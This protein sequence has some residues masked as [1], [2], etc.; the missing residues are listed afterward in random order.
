MGPQA[1]LDNGAAGHMTTVWTP[2]GKRGGSPYR[3]VWRPNLR[4]SRCP[5]T[6]GTPG[7][8]H[9]PVIGLVM[10]A[11]KPRLGDSP[12]LPPWLFHPELRPESRLQHHK[13]L[14]GFWLRSLAWPRD[15]QALGHRRVPACCLLGTRPHSRKWAVGEWERLH[16]YLQP[17]P[18][19]INTTWASNDSALW[20]VLELFHYIP[21]V[22]I[23]EIKYTIHVICLN[24]LE[25][26]PPPQSVENVPS[27]K[28]VPD[29][30]KGWEP[31]PWPKE[32]VKLTAGVLIPN[33]MFLS[34]LPTSLLPETGPVPRDPSQGWHNLLW[35]NRRTNRGS[36]GQGGRCHSRRHVHDKLGPEHTAE[37]H[38]G[39]GPSGMQGCT[40]ESAGGRTHA[41]KWQPPWGH[42]HKSSKRRKAARKKRG[43]GSWPREE[44]VQRQ[45]A[46]RVLG[47]ECRSV[48]PGRGLERGSEVETRDSEGLGVSW[49]RRK[50]WRTLSSSMMERYADI[51]DSSCGHKWGAGRERRE[52][53]ARQRAG[54][55]LPQ[56]ERGPDNALL[57]TVL[58]K[59]K[60]R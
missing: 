5:V 1:A 18:I 25:T 52:V 54:N 34:P 49:G 6:T 46:R 53:E 14:E 47:P 42:D 22:I 9:G 39:C 44:A 7:W 20:Q 21:Y 4:E 17:L 40:A 15:P 59:R 13:I 28:P 33:K 19:I 50:C 30:R 37:L 16:L 27:M 57:I 55:T 8:A 11:Q 48:R 10:G 26:I 56:G 35:V 36:P 43:H 3:T 32:C 29:A 31:L 38:S 51:W 2:E 12:K 24:H 41:H 23:I 58:L 45:K 60:C